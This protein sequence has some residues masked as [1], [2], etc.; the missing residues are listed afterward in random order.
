MSE[1]KVLVVED[2]EGLRRMIVSISSG[3]FQRG[4]G[5]RC[6]EARIAVADQLAPTCLAGLDVADQSA[7]NSPVRCGATS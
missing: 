6:H 3:R 7:P 1:R 5:R 2:D 4:R